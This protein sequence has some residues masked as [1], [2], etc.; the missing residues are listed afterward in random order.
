MGDGDSNITIDKRETRKQGREGY[1]WREGMWGFAHNGHVKQR[2]SEGEGGLSPIALKE[3]Q[4]KPNRDSNRRQDHRRLEYMLSVVPLPLLRPPTFIFDPRSLRH[5]ELKKGEGQCGMAG[6][7]TPRGASTSMPVLSARSSA[8]VQ[9]SCSASV[10]LSGWEKDN[11]AEAGA[12]S[13]A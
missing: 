13:K 1:A 7:A 8:S 10:A 9:F 12:R 4:N 5:C 11:V 6:S 3:Q 2:M